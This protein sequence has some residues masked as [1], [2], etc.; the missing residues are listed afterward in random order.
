[1]QPHPR[2]ARTTGRRLNCMKA[3]KSLNPETTFSPACSTRSPNRSAGRRS[4]LRSCAR[5]RKRRAQRPPIRPSLRSR[6]RASP[7][8]LA[9]PGRH[10]VVATRNARSGRLR[11]AGRRHVRRA[12]PL[13]LEAAESR[14]RGLARPSRRT[15]S[16]WK[17]EFATLNG[18]V[19]PHLL[20]RC[21]GRPPA[22]AAQ[23]VLTVERLSPY[24][25]CLFALRFVG[26]HGRMAA[27]PVRRDVCVLP[28]RKKGGLGG[29]RERPIGPL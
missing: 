13:A 18:S 20:T 12:R 25:R 1:M 26:N 7:E 15:S 8:R 23:Q 2:S 6:R 27:Y 28:R 17:R 16:S 3:M 24:N 21:S 14:N 4:G 19:S 22:S 29:A 10:L 9:R 11:R 5:I